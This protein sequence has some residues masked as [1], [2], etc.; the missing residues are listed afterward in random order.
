MRPPRGLTAAYLAE[1]G[2]TGAR[3]I[4]EGLQG[5]AAGMSTDSDPA[6]L[7]DRPCLRW[8]LAETSFKF[9]ASCRHTRP[10]MRC[11]L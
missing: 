8:A 5:M 9:H 10:P 7:V 3:R 6:K 2:F 11:R 4:L 1:D